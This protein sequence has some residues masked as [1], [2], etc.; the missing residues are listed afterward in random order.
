MLFHE[1]ENV[2]GIEKG[3]NNFTWTIEVDCSQNISR[4]CNWDA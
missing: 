2:F 3:I 4:I 1:M